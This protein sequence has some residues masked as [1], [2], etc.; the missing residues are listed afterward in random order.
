MP[1]VVGFVRDRRRL[2]ARLATIKNALAE[3][4]LPTKCGTGDRGRKGEERRRNG[5]EESGEKETRTRGKLGRPR[6]DR[7]G[8]YNL[9]RLPFGLIFE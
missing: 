5:E 4:F 9:I 1:S 2:V 3:R 7:G 8:G 6:G